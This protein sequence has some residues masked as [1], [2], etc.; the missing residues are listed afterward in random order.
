MHVLVKFVCLVFLAFVLSDIKHYQLTCLVS[1][2]SC[3]A[4]VFYWRDFTHM[5]RRVRW[6]LLILV[7]IYTFSTPGEYIQFFKLP[8]RPT[9]EGLIAGLTQTLTIV[10]MLASLTLVLSSTSRAKLIGGLYQMLSPLKCLGVRA[11]KFAVRIWLTLHYVESRQPLINT[12]I[13]SL[14]DALNA[15]L[16][17]HQ[18][19]NHDI[20][21]DVDAFSWQDYLWLILLL[22]SL[23][24]WVVS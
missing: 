1:V 19:S 9:Y 17:H 21:I 20:T 16:T 11:E 3:M 13:F 23:L 15:H 14:N 7:M 12:K 18:V 6:L 10:A 8:I 4:F 22:L 5:L 24:F 2:L